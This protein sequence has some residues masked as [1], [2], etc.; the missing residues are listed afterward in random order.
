MCAN[1]ALIA[2]GRMTCTPFREYTSKH[3]TP[4]GQTP[5]V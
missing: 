5:P 4:L 2:A 1:S 3:V